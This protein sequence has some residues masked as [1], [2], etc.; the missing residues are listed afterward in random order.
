MKADLLKQ[1][2]ADERV[3]AP[4]DRLLLD[5]G[6]ALALVSRAAEEGVPIV[7][8]SGVRVEGGHPEHAADFSSAVAEGHGC[9]Q[10]AEA[11]V[12]EHRGRGVAFELALGGDPIEAV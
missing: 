12:R 2:F 6:D 9:W 10:E 4:D 1:E 3:A 7:S 8:V 5:G 11:F